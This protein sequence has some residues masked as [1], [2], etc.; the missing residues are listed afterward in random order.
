M[1]LL[2]VMETH[3]TEPLMNLHSLTVTQWSITLST[4]TLVKSHSLN[5]QFMNQ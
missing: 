5:Q 1:E 2:L 3:Q 4:P